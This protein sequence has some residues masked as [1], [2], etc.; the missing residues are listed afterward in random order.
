[1]NAS[2]TAVDIVQRQVDAYNAHDLARFVAEYSDDIEIYR[3]PATEPGIRGKEQ[4]REFYAAQRFN[5]PLLRAEIV[6]RIVVGNKVVD[7]ERVFGVQDAALE[8]I[9]A[10][11]VVDGLIRRAWMFA[12]G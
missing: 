2:T 5:R 4:L 11:D 7:H 12:A 1:M 6:N 3:M 8:V 10:Y 9:V